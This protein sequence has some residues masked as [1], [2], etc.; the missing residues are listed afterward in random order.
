MA[1]KKDT[2]CRNWAFIQY[3]DSAPEDWREKLSELNI[4]LVESPLHDKDLNPDGSN[5]KAHR[6]ILVSFKGNKSFS[7]IHHDK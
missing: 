2:R 5:K 3:D 7:Q 4:E 6:H 1:S